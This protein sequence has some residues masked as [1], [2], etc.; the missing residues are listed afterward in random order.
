MLVRPF[1]SVFRGSYVSVKKSKMLPS[2]VIL[3]TLLLSQIIK[4]MPAAR[5]MTRI[6]MITRIIIL[7]FLL[8]GFFSF[9][10]FLPFW[11]DCSGVGDLAATKL[12]VS[13]SKSKAW[14]GL[15]KSSVEA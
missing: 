2:L 13:S 12:P 10:I 5:R 9:F 7:R 14:T 4:P 15:R 1:W 11:G 3:L 8:T 6:M